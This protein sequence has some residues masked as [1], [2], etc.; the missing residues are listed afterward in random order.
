M[1][2]MDN[3]DDEDEF[4]REAAGGGGGGGGSSI[5]TVSFMIAQGSVQAVKRS[6]KEDSHYP[7]MEEYDFKNDLANPVL[8][9]DLRAS[10]RIRPYQ[11]KSL[12]QMFGNGRA[13]SGIIVLPCGA[14][15]SLTG[16]ARRHM[17]SVSDEDDD[18][19]CDDD[20]DDDDDGG[21]DDDNGDDE[22]DYDDD[23]VV[24]VSGVTAASTIK[25]ATIIMCINNASV[26]QWKE[27]LITWT[28]LQPSLIKLFTSSF[29]DDLPNSSQACVVIT[30]YSMVCHGG[31]RSSRGEMMIQAVGSREWGL[32]I[33]DEVS[34]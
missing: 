21:D 1:E 22:D 10:T 7:L 12:S 18:D 23:D 25:R 24:V 34:V 13:R 29:K 3:S 19:E 32:M 31:K 15:K 28:N 26:N 17:M 14:G 6:A 8:N 33:L 2:E 27:Q 20:D 11:E 9:I 16:A 4:G 5:Q 30:T